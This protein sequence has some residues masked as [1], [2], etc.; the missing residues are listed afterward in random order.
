MPVMV[1]GIQPDEIKAAKFEESLELL[2][3][4]LRDQEWVAG[5]HI[6]IADYAIVATISTA[7]VSTVKYRIIPKKQ[8]LPE[9]VTTFSTIHLWSSSSEFLRFC[10]LFVTITNL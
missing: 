2:N 8:L 6:T 3:E 7:E 1:H 4:F 5:D 10:S 9:C